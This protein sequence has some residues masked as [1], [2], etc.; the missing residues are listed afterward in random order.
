[1]LSKLKVY[2]SFSLL[3]VFFTACHAK[4]ASPNKGY[5]VGGVYKNPVL[6][7][8]VTLPGDWVF[9]EN[10]TQERLKV[11]ADPPTGCTG[12]LCKVDVLA[13]M[14]SKPGLPQR[15]S[16]FIIAYKLA[17]EYM[18]RSHYPLRKFAEYMITDSV[19]KTAWNLSDKLTAI[20]LDGKLA[21]RILVHKHFPAAEVQGFGYVAETN[22]Y[23]FLLI[24]SA[25]SAI[26]QFVK[27]LQIALENMKLSGAD[28]EGAVR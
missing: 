4:D 11:S 2:L 6:G 9:L 21:Y 22:G 14:S 3:I 12:P 28:P 18:D 24:G 17:P 19:Q 25:G 23:V 20:Q 1:M 15:G 5:F 26:P 13:L 10:E 7:M 16:V 27:D 8:T